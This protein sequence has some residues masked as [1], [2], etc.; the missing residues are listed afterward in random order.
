MKRN[1]IFL[2][3]LT[4]F[5]AAAAMLAILLLMRSLQRNR[6]NAQLNTVRVEKIPEAELPAE[7]RSEDWF[8]G[9]WAGLV[10][11]PGEPD[12]GW[13]DF[14][15]AALNFY[16]EQACLLRIYATGQGYE[17]KIGSSVWA[18]TEH[19]MDSITLCCTTASHEAE[20]IPDSIYYEQAQ[21]EVGQTIALSY[22]AHIKSS[23][24]RA[25]VPEEHILIGAASPG[26]FDEWNHH[27]I[28]ALLPSGERRS[29]ESGVYPGRELSRQAYARRGAGPGRRRGNHPRRVRRN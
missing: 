16:A 6:Q 8:V 23:V 19:T 27:F 22:S 29:D 26:E 10:T 24:E 18:V 15:V 3:A 28:L 2:Y 11:G 4:I 17:A 1:R 25:H 21:F 13:T 12:P 5:A 7:E 20:H 9:D 14:G